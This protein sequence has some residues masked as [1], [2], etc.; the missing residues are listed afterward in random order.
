MG[1][2]VMHVD[3]DAFFAAI[4]QRDHEGYRGQPVIVG[5]LSGRGVVSTCS[6]EARRFGVHSA[7][8]MVRARRLCPQGIFYPGVLNAI[9]PYPGRFLRFLPAMRR[10]WSRFPSMKLSLI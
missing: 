9:V 7:M 4:E 8:P 10:W 6:Y 3:M 5:G 2:L 1:R